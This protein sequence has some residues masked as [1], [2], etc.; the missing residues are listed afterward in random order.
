MEIPH[1]ATKAKNDKKIEDRIAVDMGRFTSG[2]DQHGHLKFYKETPNMYETYWRW[3]N[4]T[5]I[6]TQFNK[7][8]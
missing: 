5:N 8:V 6:V 4:C 2:I 7:L 3:T 1:A